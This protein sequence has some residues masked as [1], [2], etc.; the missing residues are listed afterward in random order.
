MRVVF[1][2]LF[3]SFACADPQCACRTAL[4]AAPVSAKAA[5]KAKFPFRDAAFGAIAGA[6]KIAQGEAV[7]GDAPIAT[8]RFGD[9][10]LCAV[11]TPAGVE[12]SFDPLC[13]AVRELLAAAEEP[14]ALAASEGGWRVALH[15][16]QPEDGNRQV[17]LSPR[18]PVKWPEFVALRETLLDLVA[19]PTHPLLARL[20]RVA[21]AVDVAVSDRTLPV[22]V[23]PLT[24]RVWLAFRAFMEQRVGQVPVEAMAELASQSLPLWA[25]PV[26]FQTG[27]VPTLLDALHGDWQQQV[28]RWLA[29]AE[30][31]IAPAVEAWLGVRMFAIP[32]DRDQSLARGHAELIEGL[33]TGIRLLAALCEVR[34]EAPDPLLAVTALALGEH[35]VVARQDG[36]PVFELPRDAHEPGPRMADLDLTLESLC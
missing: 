20:A 13:P 26:G 19:E 33:A 12:L 7:D 6:A 5:P 31:S 29:P 30:R 32:L 4:R 22:A 16:F 11:A 36:L 18:K 25:E 1:P 27:D 21:A 3:D 14:V 8:A 2:A 10:P 9:F 24:P 23:P 34:Q 28:K 17:R 35:L 15:V